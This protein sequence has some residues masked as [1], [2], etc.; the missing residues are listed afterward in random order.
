MLMYFPV[1]FYCSLA[2]SPHTQIP[3][4]WIKSKQIAISSIAKLASVSLSLAFS[5]FLLVISRSTALV[6]KFTARSINT[7]QH[8]KRSPSL[9]YHKAHG[10]IYHTHHC[11][12][13]NSSI[14]FYAILLGIYDPSM[15]FHR[16]P[17]NPVHMH[18]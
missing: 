7:W 3:Q 9:Q 16:L 10:T 2:G 13:E 4:D 14:T 18:E 8:K 11:H 1:P 17:I 6:S 12:W 15:T 5:S